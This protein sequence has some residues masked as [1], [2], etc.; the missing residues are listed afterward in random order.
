[1]SFLPIHPVLP[2]L[3]EALAARRNAILEAPPGAGKAT[4]VPLALLEAP[5]PA[6]PR[7]V[8]LEPR[9]LAARAAAVRM[10]ETLGER[11]D[12]T[13]NYR[14]RLDTRV[15]PR[16]CI[17]VVTEGILTRMMQQDPFLE[18]VGLVIFDEFHERNLHGDLG[19]ALCLDVQRGLRE[20]LRL[21][22][23]SATLEG[24]AVAHLLGDAPVIRSRG[25][26]HPVETRYLERP[27]LTVYR[28][29][30]CVR[31]RHNAVETGRPE[32]QRPGAVPEN[33]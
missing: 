27:P 32:L 29:P 16:T 13:V 20:D 25:R 6:A 21:L 18:E 2:A 9:R 15:G 3:R 31:Y 30:G 17:E 24:N 23:M 4:R 10:A 8:M 14:V 5:W 12:Q 28:C 22:A 1:M 19:P 7:I 26:S 33:S 11:I